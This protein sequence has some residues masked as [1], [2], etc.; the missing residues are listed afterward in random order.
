MNI[1]LKVCSRGVA[2]VEEINN[3]KDV[4]L[5]WLKQESLDAHNAETYSRNGESTDFDEGIFKGRE[6]MANEV[7][8]IINNG[9]EFEEKNGKLE[10][11]F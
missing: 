1:S 2:V 11:V 7:I 3:K 10:P 5:Q 4:F 6:E 8:K 9:C